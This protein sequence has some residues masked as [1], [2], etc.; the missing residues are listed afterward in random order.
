MP[1]YMKKVKLM[2]RNLKPALQDKLVQNDLNPQ[3]ILRDPT[4]NDS[5]NDDSQDE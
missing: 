3:E 5:K 2:S 4:D 1:I